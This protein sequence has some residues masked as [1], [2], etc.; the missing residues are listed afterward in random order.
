M[1]R[2]DVLHYASELVVRPNEGA[3]QVVYNDVIWSVS[4][5]ASEVI[6]PY[7]W[8]FI[9]VDYNIDGTKRGIVK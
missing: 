7:W 5:S 9:L 8:H 4:G 2:Y 6:W 3:L 1:V